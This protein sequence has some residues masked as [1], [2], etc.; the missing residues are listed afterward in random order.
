MFVEWPLEA[1]PLKAGELTDLVKRYGVRNIVGLQ[2]GKSPVVKKMKELIEQGAI[3]R[4]EASNVVAKAYGG[5]TMASHVD[6]F[7]DKEVGG[8]ILTIAFGHALECILEG[9]AHCNQHWRRLIM[10]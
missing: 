2:G 4:V 7:V 10:I 3:G 5:S 6:Y 1:N 8:N 9:E